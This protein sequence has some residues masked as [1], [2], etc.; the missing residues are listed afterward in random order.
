MTDQQWENLI[1]IIKGTEQASLS[2]AFVIDSP[3]LPGWYGAQ[4]IDYFSNDEIW[5]KANLHAEKTFPDITF[6]PGFWAEFGMCTEPSAFGAKCSFPQNEF[7][8]AH[9]CI[10]SIDDIGKLDEPNP[11][12]DGLAPLVLNRLKLNQNLIED[13]GHKIRFS[14]SRGPLNIA[15]YLMGTTEFLMAIMT[16]PEEIHKLLRMITNYLVKWHKLQRHMFPTIDGIFALDDIVGFIGE[17]QFK[18]F[19]LPYLKDLYNQ[20]AAVKFFHNDAA[21]EASVSYMPEIGVNLFN[22]G[23]ET[24]LNNLKQ[25]T[26][27][28]VTM[29][30]NIPPRDVLANGTV[31]DVKHSVSTLIGSLDNHQKVLISCGGG[32]PP[33][34][35]TENLQA[36]VE[37]VRD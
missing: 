3:W 23:F 19:G 28:Q 16:N 26:N 2:A 18:E 31:E 20:D 25:V 27:N 11:E 21:C 30:G 37:A 13:S 7:P 5:L 17:D 24:D 34:V 10:H 14:V 36:F 29:L 6:L 1:H 12:V 33:G 32:M 35:S 15:S 22:M 8:H 4:M 9:K